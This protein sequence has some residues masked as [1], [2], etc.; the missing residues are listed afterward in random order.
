LTNFFS[1]L[2]STQHLLNVLI[3]IENKKGIKEIA[4]ATVA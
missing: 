1:F 3:E 4:V 2:I